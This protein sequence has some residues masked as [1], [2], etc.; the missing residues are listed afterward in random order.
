M[1]GNEI[2]FMIFFSFFNGMSVVEKEDWENVIN[3]VT[4]TKQV[5]SSVQDL[6]QKLTD[7]VILGNNRTSSYKLALHSPQD[8]QALLL[9][10]SQL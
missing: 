10:F 4:N 5:M 9:N 2:G 7:Y 6:A 8:C 1:D 3:L